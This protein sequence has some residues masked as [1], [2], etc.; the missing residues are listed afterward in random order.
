ME[1]K[2]IKELILTDYSDGEID[3][4]LKEEI[5]AHLAA[6][7]VCRQLAGALRKTVIEPFKK[8]EAVKPPDVIW[9]RITEAIMSEKERQPA[10]LFE[11][12]R[13]FLQGAYSVPRPVY[14]TAAIMF[15]LLMAAVFARLPVQQQRVVN[16]Y[17]QD[18]MEF[19]V[20]LK[21]EPTTAAYD[22]LATKIEKSFL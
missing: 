15:V 6:C 8:I 1:C 7:A 12:V 14:A 5:E 16:K 18:E 17:L 3:A 4:G 13:D 21:A 9:Y 2:K 20:N 11:R 22:S 10:G 19:V